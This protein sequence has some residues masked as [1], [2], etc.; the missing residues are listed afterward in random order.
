MTSY[1][2]PLGL[3]AGLAERKAHAL[4]WLERNR[5][6][7]LWL[8]VVLL[9]A[10]LLARDLT[11]DAPPALVLREPQVATGT[12]LVHIAGGVSAPGLYDLPSGARVH[13]ALLAAG[14]ALPGTDFDSINLARWLRDGEKITVPVLQ[15]NIEA[16]VATLAPGEVLDINAASAEQLDQLPGIGEAYSRRIVDSRIVDGPYETVDDLVTRRVIPAN[17]LD[18]IR[19]RLSVSGP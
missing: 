2:R 3:L 16:V 10:G 8:L 11:N 12:I 6:L 9:L 15:A 14:G 18:Q 17:T 7:L 4:D 19:D 5:I 13:D 1:K